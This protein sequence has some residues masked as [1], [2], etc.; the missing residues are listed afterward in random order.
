MK[1]SAIMMTF[2]FA[3]CSVSQSTPAA[4][5]RV[6]IATDGGIAGRGIGTYA[7]DSDGLVSIVSMNGKLC[8]FRATDEELARIE[9]ILGDARPDAWSDSYVPAERCCDRIYYRLKI[10]QRGGTR[11]LSWIDDPLP[12]P[13]D[14]LALTRAIIGGPE[15]LR[16][17]YGEQCR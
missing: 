16:V 9:Q 14:L 8:E 5:W 4:P 2:M 13:D 1:L 6:E 7:I 15:S 10:E 12:M 3:A 17:R 11:T